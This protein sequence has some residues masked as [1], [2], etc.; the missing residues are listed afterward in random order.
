MFERKGERL[1]P[2]SSF[3]R[4][5]GMSL[6]FALG[7]SGVGL[8]IGTIGYHVFAGLGWLDAELNAAMILTGMGPV[9]PMQ[10]P[11]AKIFSSIYALFSGVV[12]LSSTGIVLSP[13]F[14]RVIHTFHLAEDDSSEPTDDAA[15][16]PVRPRTTGVRPL[17]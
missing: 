8:L 15:A 10:T 14:H 4:R 6:A 7:L 2:F 3:L 9:S 12:F 5:L 1:L 11:G 17:K 13:V 16:K